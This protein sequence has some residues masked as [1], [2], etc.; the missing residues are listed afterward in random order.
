MFHPNPEEN[1]KFILLLSQTLMTAEALHDRKLISPTKQ[2]ETSR[3]ADR[4]RLLICFPFIFFIVS[5]SSVFICSLKKNKNFQKNLLNQASTLQAGCLAQGLTCVHVEQCSM[6]SSL[7]EIPEG[8]D[9][10]QPLQ[11]DGNPGG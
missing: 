4:S 11:Q 8:S 2:E 3:N 9:S 7:Q 6:K 5:L 10:T 1:Q